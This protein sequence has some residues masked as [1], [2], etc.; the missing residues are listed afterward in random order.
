MTKPE[1]LLAAFKKNLGEWV[2]RVHNSGG[3]SQPAATF[4]S[5][6]QQGY[7]FE[8]VSSGHWDKYIYCKTCEGKTTHSKLLSSDPLFSARP[9]IAISAKDRVRI[10]KLF[11]ERDAFTGSSIS[12]TPE[13][14][15]KIPFTRLE[16][17]IDASQMT[18]EEILSHFQLLTREHNLLK[19]RNCQ[20][21]KQNDIRPPFLGLEFW[22][23]GNS[24]YINTCTGCG[25]HDGKKWSIELNK[26]IK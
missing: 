16:K 13:I 7:S 10:L 22:Y 19:D 18:D 5:L 11:E 26:K 15:H 6:K 3:A 24:E 20:S 21:C 14:D 9:R 8:E 4:R 1:I 17:D 2:C 25:W 12:S 23:E